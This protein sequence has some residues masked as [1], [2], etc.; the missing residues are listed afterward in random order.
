[1]LTLFACGVFLMMYATVSVSGGLKGSVASG[2]G[3]GYSMPSGSAS[4]RL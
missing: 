4:T 3:I 2:T 1:M